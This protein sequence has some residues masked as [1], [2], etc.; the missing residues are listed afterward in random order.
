MSNDPSRVIELTDLFRIAEWQGELAWQPFQEGVEIFRLYGQGQAGP[1]AALLRFRPG[2]K[3]K[4][5]EHTGFEHILVLSGSQVDQHGLAEAGSLIVNP[6]GSSHSIVSETGCIVLAI[7]EK[8]VR[9]VPPPSS[10]S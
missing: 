1:A 7:Y 3:V 4:W 5:H 8:P 10:T 2:G 9:F 6:P